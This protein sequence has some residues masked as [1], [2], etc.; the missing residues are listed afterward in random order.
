MDA[1]AFQNDFQRGVQRAFY[2]LINQTSKRVDIDLFVD[3]PLRADVPK[4]C[5]VT[6]R[7][8]YFPTRRSNLPLRAWNKFRKTF[9]STPLKRPDVF[10]ST[11]FTLSPFRDVP[12]VVTVHDMIPELHGELCGDW[13]HQFVSVKARILRAATLIIAIS[14]STA[15][16]IATVYPDAKAK[17]RVVHHGADHFLPERGNSPNGSVPI[18]IAGPFALFVGDRGQ[19]KNF[20]AIKQALSAN[21]WPKEL[22]LV[23][24]GPQL[25]AEERKELERS[26]VFSRVRDLG[27]VDDMQL[28]KLYRQ[29][30]AFIFPS[31]AEGFG[32]PLLEAQ[33]NGAPVVCSDIPVFHEIG[34]DSVCFFDTSK[35]S[36]I[37]ETLQRLL[38]PRYREQIKDA[39]RNNVL[40]FSWNACAEA[41]LQ[42]YREAMEIGSPKRRYI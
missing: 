8:E 22:T 23:I 40:R 31:L 41:T 11:Y 38:E 10:H 15:V 37:G 20:S 14:K 9:L 3:G 16:D 29:C 6:Y 27:R 26:N 28:A 35:P 36:E 32:F 39:G 33:A 30:V 2:Q 34:A 21:T 4:E 25:T 19:Y 13:V 7:R 42:T 12:Q 1:V 17:T 18:E 24:V 5:S